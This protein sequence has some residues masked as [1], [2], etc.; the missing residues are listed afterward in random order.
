MFIDQTIK[1]GE[2]KGKSFK[3]YIS[4]L[5]NYRIYKLKKDQIKD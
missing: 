5:Y 2:Q 4:N 3:K 1:D